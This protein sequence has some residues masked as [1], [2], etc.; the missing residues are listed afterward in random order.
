MFEELFTVEFIV[1][2]DRRLEQITGERPYS[3]M[4]LT[5]KTIIACDTNFPTAQAHLHLPSVPQVGDV[6]RL[7]YTRTYEYNYEQV[8]KESSDES[9]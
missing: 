3:A 1:R 9:A 4:F 2:E 5:D 8:K 7:K 6:I